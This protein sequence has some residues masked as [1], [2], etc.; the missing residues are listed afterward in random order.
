MLPGLTGIAGDPK[1]SGNA[2]KTDKTARVVHSLAPASISLV[3]VHPLE[4]RLR[5]A[6]TLSRMRVEMY[7][8]P[9]VFR[10]GGLKLLVYEVL[11]Y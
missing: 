11:R 6:L 1:L 9:S 5:L 10:V 3:A 4:A 8:R 2:A 7:R